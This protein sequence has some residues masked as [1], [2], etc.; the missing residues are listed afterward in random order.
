MASELGATE[1]VGNGYANCLTTAQIVMPR[2]R[3]A[4]M[5][6]RGGEEKGV[7][8][9]EN[10]S[11]ALARIK[12]MQLFPTRV[13]EERAE[14]FSLQDSPFSRFGK[15]GGSGQKGRVG[16][17]SG[18]LGLQSNVAI[19]RLRNRV[20][21]RVLGVFTTELATLLQAG[22][23]LLRGLRVLERQKRSGN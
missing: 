22:L 21:N 12:E 18:K 14:L 7:L 15:R 13:V 17:R 1:S 10:Q 8:E 2:F 19:P 9:P 4:A 5:N 20:S 11:M 23:P 16:S 3:Y 6:S